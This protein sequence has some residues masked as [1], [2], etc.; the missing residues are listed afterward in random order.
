MHVNTLEI[1]FEKKLFLCFF[2]FYFRRSDSLN[3]YNT[4]LKQSCSAFTSV[5]SA[6]EVN[7]NAL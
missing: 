4:S 5:N 3:I 2:L 7:L 1:K 6:L